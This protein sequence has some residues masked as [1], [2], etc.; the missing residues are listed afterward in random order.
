VAAAYFFG[1]FMRLSGAAKAAQAWSVQLMHRLSRCIV[2][3]PH[4]TTLLSSTLRQS[5]ALFPNHH[6]V[7]NAEILPETLPTGVYFAVDVRF[8]IHTDF[9]FKHSLVLQL[10]P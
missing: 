1:G 8:E 9:R 10:P 2:Q 3:G 7:A 5:P 6:A 4:S